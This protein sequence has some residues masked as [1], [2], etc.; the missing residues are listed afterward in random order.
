[1]IFEYFSLKTKKV[2][3]VFKHITRNC[4]KNNL[5]AENALCT[6]PDFGG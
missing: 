5:S 4:W 1:M 6:Q 2:P 3:D